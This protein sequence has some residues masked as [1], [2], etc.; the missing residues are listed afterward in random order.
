MS[1]FAGMQAS[2]PKRT[3]IYFCDVLE[4]YITYKESMNGAS[5]YEVE[6]QEKSAELSMN[7]WVTRGNWRKRNSNLNTKIED[8]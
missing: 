7:K 5:L 8:Q 4:F 2:W 1:S 6:W 3:F